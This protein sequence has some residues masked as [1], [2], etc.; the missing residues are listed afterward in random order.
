MRLPPGRAWG[1]VHFTG[2]AVLGSYPHIAYDMMLSE[3]C[4]TSGLMVIATP[5]DLGTDHD[6]IKEVV[7]TKLVRHLLVGKSRRNNTDPASDPA[8]EDAHA[9]K[10][11]GS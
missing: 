3:L 5:Y 1:V 4:D 9:S 6:A 2:G 7:T 10:T 8:F 11:Y